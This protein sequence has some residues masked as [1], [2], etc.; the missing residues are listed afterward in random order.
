VLADLSSG[1]LPESS[2]VNQLK[3]IFLVSEDATGM[4]GPLVDELWRD[5]TFSLSSPGV[6]Y[7][8]DKYWGTKWLPNSLRGTADQEVTVISDKTVDDAMYYQL[9]AT[10][11]TEDEVDDTEGGPSEEED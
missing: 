9:L 11:G 7:I 4:Y 10:R 5:F 6:T 2:V 3:Q 8:W 1:K